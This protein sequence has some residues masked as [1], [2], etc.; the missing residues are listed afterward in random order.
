M[1]KKKTRLPKFCR[2]KST[3]MGY[4]KIKGKFTYFGDYDDDASREKYDQFIAEYL[5]AGRKEPNKG[6]I[7]AV[8]F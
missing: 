7:R 3:N 2:H 8:L 5:S 4:V 6:N 1:S